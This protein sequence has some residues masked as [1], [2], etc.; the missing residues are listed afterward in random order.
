MIC[1]T[2]SL[3]VCYEIQINARDQSK[4]LHIHRRSVAFRNQ[5]QCGRT[6]TIVRLIAST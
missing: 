3:S 6:N 5:E 2:H 1:L 4:D